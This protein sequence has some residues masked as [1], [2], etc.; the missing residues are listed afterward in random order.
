MKISI[1]RITYRLAMLLALLSIQGMLAACGQEP[2]TEALEPQII[3]SEPA[4]NSTEDSVADTS[5]TTPPETEEIE[6]EVDAMQEMFG[7][8]C[9]SD[10]T[11]EVQL[12]EY[13]QQVYFVPFVPSPE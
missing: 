13:D 12:S 3:S 11:F 6:E 10:Q 9:I 2:E 1:K 4:E 5:E 7:K 8:D